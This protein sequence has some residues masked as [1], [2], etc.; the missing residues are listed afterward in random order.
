[1]RIALLHLMTSINQN[2]VR[3]ASLGRKRIC[4]WR[5]ARRRRRW[6]RSFRLWYRRRRA[7]AEHAGGSAADAGEEGGW[8]ARRACRG[9]LVL[10]RASSW[11][12][13]GSEPCCSINACDQQNPSRVRRRT[14]ARARKETRFVSC[15]T[16]RRCT[17]TVSAVHDTRFAT[18]L[19]HVRLAVQLRVLLSAR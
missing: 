13:P 15:H 2:V 14:R 16:R 12:M 8:R 1:M 6:R 18:F 19:A 11:V 5:E 17:T 10:Q 4:R 3:P 9:R 7:V